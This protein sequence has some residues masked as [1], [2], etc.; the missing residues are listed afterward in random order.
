[1]VPGSWPGWAGRVAVA[2]RRCRRR[3]AALARA[4]QDAEEVAADEQRVE[5]DQHER[6]RHGR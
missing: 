5:R 1:M 3:L 2:A 6:L 4:A